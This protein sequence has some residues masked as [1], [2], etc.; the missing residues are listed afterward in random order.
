MRLFSIQDIHQ[1]LL[2]H[3]LSISMS[4]Q[5]NCFIWYISEPLTS[6]DVSFQ[7]NESTSTFVIVQMLSTNFLL[8]CDL[9]ITKKNEKRHQYYNLR[10]DI[11]PSICLIFSPFFINVCYKCQT[12]NPLHFSIK[13]RN[14]FAYAFIMHKKLCINK[15]IWL[16]WNFSRMYAQVD[17]WNSCLRNVSTRFGP[18]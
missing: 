18:L 15:Y 12:P 4:F 9:S 6:M 5:N 7:L 8:I 10:N 11:K 1:S 13:P 2:V 16:M 3:L 17:S 14:W